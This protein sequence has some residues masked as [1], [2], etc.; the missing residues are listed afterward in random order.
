MKDYSKVST[1]GKE[2]LAFIGLSHN[3]HTAIFLDLFLFLTDSI[4]SPN[5]ARNPFHQNTTSILTK[6]NGKLVNLTKLLFGDL[7]RHG[8]LF[9]FN[10]L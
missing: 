3:V 2:K 7:V 8:H 10:H 9:V 5:A 6:L 4:A 1:D